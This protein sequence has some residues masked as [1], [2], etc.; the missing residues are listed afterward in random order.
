MLTFQIAKK[1]LLLITNN[2]YDVL[3]IC[4]VLYLLNV[5]FNIIGVYVFAGIWTV[6]PVKF[7]DEEINFG[8]FALM[9]IGSMLVS[10]IVTLWVAVTWHRYVLLEEA[11]NGWIPR[12][13]KSANL[14]YFYQFLKLVPILF[15]LRLVIA[16]IIAT[17]FGITGNTGLLFFVPIVVMSVAFGFTVLKMSL[18]LP[19]AAVET[20][21]GVVDS[22]SMTGPYNKTLLALTIASVGFGFLY[23]TIASL[24]DVN[25]FTS[26]IKFFLNAFIGFWW[27]SVLTTLYCI[28][29]EGR[30]MEG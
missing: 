25:M 26:S 14:S 15:V 17:S 27:L 1:S 24:L 29:V 9:V 20:N 3:R 4:A 8:L 6:V 30:E 19:S 5:I 7:D 21:M 23:E 18:I 16:V 22:W 10:A 13:N 28:I 12:W 2:F 11:P